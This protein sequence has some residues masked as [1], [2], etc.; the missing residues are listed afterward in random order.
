LVSHPRKM[1]IRDISGS[2]QHLDQIR[3]MT[4]K[5]T[6]TVEHLVLIFS[7]DTDEEEGKGHSPSLG[8]EYAQLF[9][10]AECFKRVNRLEIELYGQSNFAH[11]FASLNE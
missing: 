6:N 7:S 5:V 3:A 1:T 8:E 4:E 9:A 11:I 10:T 2:K